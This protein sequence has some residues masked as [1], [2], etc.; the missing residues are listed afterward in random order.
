[1]NSFL[2][3]IFIG[4]IFICILSLE[5][6]AADRYW[7]GGTATWDGTAGTKWDTVSGGGGGAAVP[8]AAD[9]C[10][11]DASSGAVTV[12][13]S[14]L[15]TVNCRSI[16]FTGFTGTLSHP[17]N[18][19][20]NV[21]DGT[22]GNTIFYSGM[23]Y[24]I[25]SATTS[26]IIFKSTAI[27]NQI[28]FAG[29]TMPMVTFNGP[30]GSWIFQDSLTTGSLSRVNL[31]EGTLRWDGNSD[32][33]GLTHT[34]GSFISDNTNTRV[35]TLGDST[36][37]ASQDSTPWTC[38][39]G[40]NLTV[41][42]GNS[43]I[44]LTG[45][46]AT[47]NNGSSSSPKNY[48]ELRITGAGTATLKGSATYAKLE[49]TGTASSDDSFTIE[50]GSN[51]VT[52]TFTLAGN[53]ASNRLFVSSGVIGTA[54]TITNTGITE[55]FSNVDFRDIRL[56]ESY[57][58]SSITGG[59]G[60]CGG[61]SNLTFTTAVPQYWYRNTGNWSD[62]TKWF[63]ASG[64]SGA[65][66]VPLPQDDAIFDS[67]SFSIN[68]QTITTDM[69]RIG[70][71]IYWNSTT[72]NATWS[73]PISSSQIMYGALSLN[74][75]MTVSQ[76]SSHTLY[77]NGRSH[78]TILR[79]GRTLAGGVRITAIGGSITMLDSF[80]CSQDIILYAGDLYGNGF[81]IN[82]NRSFATSGALTRSY[83]IG[84]GGFSAF[85]SAT[86]TWWNISGSNYTIDASD[87]TISVAGTN[88]N[89]KTFAG[90]GRTYNNLRIYGTNTSQHNFTGSNTFNVFTIDTSTAAS[91]T[92]K[93]TAG[94]TTTIG[95]LI[96]IGT[97]TKT[98]TIDTITAATHTLSKS[99]GLV[100]GDYLS[101]KNSVATG[102]AVWYAG[103]HSTNV[104]G[105]TGWK[106]LSCGNRQGFMDFLP[107]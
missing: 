45:A 26:Y 54:I 71:S 19:W 12:T 56:S 79:S 92:V 36:I 38:T 77:F 30:G 62:A 6:I 15:N 70:R 3:H 8:T 58:A 64:G 55:V 94:T 83:V 101:I 98:I 14:G 48:N 91:K 57:D 5:A 43:I 34:I 39:N 2:R 72:N 81:E 69:P 59:S 74:N 99:S 67:A 76:S 35:N 18:T 17:A 27:G 29:K 11:F 65:G 105:N 82:S 86:V 90:A 61:N 50:G 88:N 1:M 60:D 96:A 44:I 104:S 33:S 84:S 87:S 23:T 106:F 47:F 13:I 51:I 42:A 22:A 21:G 52:N 40:S 100:C 31:A 95:S 25:G 24:T 16:D 46:G 28:T 41:N 73:L 89:V 107:K 63:T 9:S 75:N 93:F 49:R 80:Y 68:S 7:V 4:L 53:S 32:N 20:I 37:T 103:N 85:P 97:P 10:F 78:N 66:R 102:G